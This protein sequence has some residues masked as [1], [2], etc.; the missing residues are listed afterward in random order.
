MT[1]N[2]LVASLEA[3]MRSALDLAGE[4]QELENVEPDV[5]DMFEKLITS[6][7]DLISM[8]AGRDSGQGS[9][10]FAPFF[11]FLADSSDGDEHGFTQRG[12]VEAAIS[13]AAG[14][15]GSTKRGCNL[16]LICQDFLACNDFTQGGSIDIR[17][18]L[19]KFARLL[20][21][22]IIAVDVNGRPVLNG[23]L[24]S[25]LVDE[26]VRESGD[27]QVQQQLAEVSDRLD[28]LQNRG[29]PRLLAKELLRLISDRGCTFTIGDI[30]HGDDVEKWHD[31]EKE[32]GSS[33]PTGTDTA[34]DGLS[35]SSRLMAAEI[36]ATSRRRHKQRRSNGQLKSKSTPKSSRRRVPGTSTSS[37]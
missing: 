27:S 28:V 7:E 8:L 37:T 15:S 25:R 5:I 18:L 31:E 10:F 34:A 6:H 4:L 11:A 3:R 9:E 23:E 21:V 35:S 12:I 29:S 19:S 1:K 26:G 13:R 2:Q 32:S 36:L 24:L 20:G 22:L 30:A 14:M 33:A 16:E 17:S